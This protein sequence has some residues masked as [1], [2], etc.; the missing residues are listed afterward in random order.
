VNALQRSPSIED[1]IVGSCPTVPGDLWIA[2]VS[3]CAP[4]PVRSMLRERA[5]PSTRGVPWGADLLGPSLGCSHECCDISLLR[6]SR[7]HTSRRDGLRGC[8]ARAS[9]SREDTVPQERKACPAIALAFKQLQTVDMTLSTGPLL[10]GSVSPAVIAARSSRR[11]WAKRASASIPLAVVSVIHASRASP[12][13]SRTS[14]RN[15]WLSVYACAMAG[16]PWVSSSI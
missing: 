5:V 6:S 12:R 2:D 16:A 9:A 15:A 1:T 8:S 13:C 3:R 7:G 14:A 11:P 10:Q 4:S